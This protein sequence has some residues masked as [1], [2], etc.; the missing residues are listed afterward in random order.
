MTR[1]PVVL[2][3]GATDG[4]GKGVAVDLARRG[5]TVLVHG[6]DP[7]RLSRTAE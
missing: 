2:V 5:A 1:S 7:G 4:L 6:R 3:T